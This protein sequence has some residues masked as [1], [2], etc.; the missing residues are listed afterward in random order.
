V[1]FEPIVPIWALLAV[2]AAGIALAWFQYLRRTV[3]GLKPTT[4]IILFS[5]R[6]A[7]FLVFA[8]LLCNPQWTRETSQELPPRLLILFDASES[9]NSLEGPGKPTAFAKLR[10]AFFRTVY[11]LWENRFQLRFYTFSSQV[12]PTDPESLRELD[13]VSGSATDIRGAVSE[14]LSQQGNNPPAAVMLLTDG[15]HNWG[16]EPTADIFRREDDQDSVP[17]IA[18]SAEAYGEL[19]KSLAIPQMTVPDAVFSKEETDIRFQIVASGAENVVAQTNLTVEFNPEPEV[20]QEVPGGDRTQMIQLL[21]SSTEGIFTNTFEEGGRYRLTLQTSAEGLGSASAVR[22]IQVEPGRW[23]IAYF[24]GRAGWFSASLIRR[25]WFVPRYSMKAAIGLGPGKW[26][27]LESGAEEE[28]KRKEFLS[29]DEIAHEA[30]LFIFE[31]LQP[32]QVVDFPTDIIRERVEEGAAIL[33]VTGSGEPVPYNFL[34]SRGIDPFAPVDLKSAYF[35]PGIK[36]IDWTDAAA[37]NSIT[38]SPILL[39][40]PGK[41][42]AAHFSVGGVGALPEAETLLGFSD[43]SPALT[44]RTTGET[45]T[46]YLAVTDLW[47]WQF[48]PGDRNGPYFRAYGALL[49]RLLRWLILGEVE[50]E[51]RPQLIISQSRVPLGKPIEVG[52]QY[53]RATEQATATVRLNVK[54]PAGQL[55]PVPLQSQAGGFFST[56]YAP[57]EAGEY[58]FYVADPEIPSASD[59]AT[60]Q[61]EPF[62]IETAVSGARVDL[63]Q[64]LAADTGGVWVDLKDM[65]QIPKIERVEDI[66]KPRIIIRSV[67][68]PVMSA[69]WFFLILILL[70]CF[71]WGLRRLKD[72]P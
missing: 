68:E 46:A 27:F 45:R 33:L 1:T 20:W 38:N 56:R 5:L 42:P 4:R 62:S 22:E 52:V 23:K 6:V 72:L 28:K 36:D 12:F 18:V 29:F 49:D 54:D 11:P 69:P 65:A 44:V 32:E 48:Q 25:I 60:V 50:S 47:R 31:G 57:A 39:G 51:G 34:E 67:T 59:Q 9:M 21:G 13:S 53:S 70:A 24:S 58:T 66:Y 40:L 16:P 10:E 35:A 61:V 30:D 17:L 55:V 15:N 3:Y 26:V 19:K 43:G 37:A 64:N 63:L 14:V 2:A 8:F 71:E 7:V 41:L